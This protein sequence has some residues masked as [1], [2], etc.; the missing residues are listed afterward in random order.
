MNRYLR[1]S[2]I[3][4][5]LVTAAGVSAADA[6]SDAKDFSRYQ[7]IIDRS[8]FGQVSGAGAAAPLPNFATRFQFAGLVSSD[9]GPLQAI[10]YD[11]DASRTYF[12]VEGEVI[13]SDNNPIDVKVVQIDPPPSAKLVLK[14]GVETATLQFEE[15]AGGSA[16]SR[17]P[18]VVPPGFK[19]P[20]SS[21]P[22]P[23]VTGSRRIPFRRTN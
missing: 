8:P 12:C 6:P 17:T 19:P 14:C 4:G 15:R 11:K 5:L 23:N 20:G 21:I 7:V 18:P 16:A 1:L 9:E 3:G 10:L 13:K 22:M 2:L